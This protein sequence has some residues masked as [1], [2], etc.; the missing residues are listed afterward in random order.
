MRR[1]P[2][3]AGS[4]FRAF[5][6]KNKAKRPSRLSLPFPSPSTANTVSSFSDLLLP[7]PSNPLH[8]HPFII[9]FFLYPWSLPLFLP[10]PGS[11]F[12]TFSRRHGIL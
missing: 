2:E 7:F 12:Q 5:I 6:L 3:G 10:P 11:V 9:L 8:S 4:A 1:H